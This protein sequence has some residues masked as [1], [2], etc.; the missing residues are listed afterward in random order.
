MIIPTPPQIPNVRIGEPI[1]SLAVPPRRR[2][3]LA[4]SD[5]GEIAA[6]V[7]PA[8]YPQAVYSIS[9]EWR[10]HL[11]RHHGHRPQRLRLQRA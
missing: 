10:E 11:I 6:F 3:T 7:V 4:C 8:E 5:C 1:H 2:Y 9:R